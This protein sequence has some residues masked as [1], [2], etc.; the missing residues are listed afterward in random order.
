LGKK[1][2]HRSEI[3][4]YLAQSV[5]DVKDALSWWYK[6]RHAFPTLSRMA[7]DYLSIPGECPL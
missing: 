1:V 3:D 7:R 5:E 6:Q 4:E 2:A